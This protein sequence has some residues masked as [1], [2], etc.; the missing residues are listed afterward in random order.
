VGDVAGVRIEP[1][2]G[3]L[4]PTVPPELDPELWKGSIERVREWR[5]AALAITHFGRFDDVDAHLDA[6]REGLGRLLATEGDEERVREH[7]AGLVGGSGAAEAGRYQQAAA[8]A[9]LAAGV[10]RHLERREG[11]PRAVS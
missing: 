9:M 3:V 10:R 4:M 8:P 7:V 2:Q 1:A 5:P 11:D 6:A